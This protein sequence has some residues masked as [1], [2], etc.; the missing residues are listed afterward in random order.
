MEVYIGCDNILGIAVFSGGS[1]RLSGRPGGGSSGPGA[2]RRKPP[3]PKTRRILYNL[4]GVSCMFVKK[5]SKGPT[6][7][8]SEDLKVIVGEI[9]YPG[10]QVDTLLVCINAQCTFY[11]SKVGNMRGTLATPEQRKKWPATQQ[12]HFRNV[13]AMLAQGVDPYALLLAE[14]KKR[15][16]ESLLS[17]RMNDAHGRD[18]LHCKLWLDHPDYRLGEGLDF[19]QEAVARVHVPADRRS[20]PT[21]RL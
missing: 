4:D 20:S 18:F 16:L 1:G 15:G 2:G 10:S 12:H 9:A 19:G 7:V 17:Y 11:P 6:R 3:T 21:L 14:A 5:G 8:T 13:E